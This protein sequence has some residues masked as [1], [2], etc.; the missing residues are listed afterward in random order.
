MKTKIIIF[1][2]LLTIVIMGSSSIFNFDFL[3][4][5]SM[6]VN[7]TSYDNSWKLID[8]LINRNL[9]QSAMQEVELV[10]NKAKSE[11]NVPQ[12]VKTL[13]YKAKLVDFRE[14]KSY[15]KIFAFFDDEISTARPPLKNI[16]HSVKAE[17]MWR[18]YSIN[19][20]KF[21]NRTQT[22]DFDN[23]DIETWDLKTLVDAII[24]E[25]YMAL[26]F[27]DTLKKTNLDYI[28]PILSPN[29]ADPVF[30]PTLYDFIV[31]RAITFF[32]NEEPD[33]TRPA[34]YFKI[35]DVRYFNV[36]R[37]FTNLSITNS[38]SLSLKFYALSLFQNLTAFH[39]HSDYDAALM[40]VE[41]KRL[42]FVYN[43]FEGDE[44]D[45][46]LYNA[47]L[48]LEAY[49]NGKPESAEASFEIANMDFIRG[50]KYN[51]RMG[52]E[53]KWDMK[54]AH[55]KCIEVISRYPDT[56]GAKNCLNLKERILETKIT[57]KNENFVPSNTPFLSGIEYKNI[58]KAYFRIVKSDYHTM[59][60]LLR[61]SISREALVEKFIN[62]RPVQEFS[63]DM[64][65]D[66]DYQMHSTEV[67]M[68]ELPLGYYLIIVSDNE[69]F[70]Y[71]SG[72]FAYS[73]VCI[74]DISYVSRRN[75]QG[76]YEIFVL[77]RTNG[78][79]IANAKL[80]A[81]IEDYNYRTRTYESKKWKTFTSDSEGFIKIPAERRDDY[82]SFYIEITHGDD[83][84][85]SDR[86]FYL[87][88]S[89]D[90]DVESIISTT[91]F[92]DRAIY[93]PGQTVF[94]KGIV[95]ETTGERKEIKTNYR[96]KVT[97][98]DVNSQQVGEL[99]LVSNEFGTISGSFVIP[100]G[101]MT[102]SM[103]IRSLNSAK[104]FNVEE[105]KR[106]KFEVTFEPLKGVYRLNENINAKGKAMAYA[107]NSIDGAQVQYR[108]V[109]NA[110]FPYSYY[111]WRWAFPTS[112]EVVIKVGNTTT[113]SEGL[114]EIEFNAI[115]DN[116][117]NRRFKPVF[118]Y[119]IYADVTDITGEVRSSQTTISVG[120]TALLLSAEVPERIDKNN[121]E[122]FKISTTN[123]NGEK[124]PT[125]CTVKIYRLKQ[126]AS[127]YRSRIWEAPDNNTLSESEFRRLFPKDEYKDENNVENWE[128]EE[129]VSETV[130][131]TTEI[132][133]FLPRNFERWQSGKYIME[134]SAND[135]FNQE[136]NKNYHFTLFADSDRS[137]PTN[138]ISWIKFDKTL[139]EPGE[140]VSFTL[141]TAETDVNVIYELEYGPDSIIRRW[142]NLNKE[143]KRFEIPV[144]EQDR[145]NFQVHFTFVKDNRT[146]FH[147]QAISVPHTDKVLDIQYATFRDKLQPGQNEEWRITIKDHKGDKMLAEL[148]TAMYDASLDAFV[149]NNW[150]FNILNY[151]YSS[152]YWEGATAFGTQNALVYSL[153]QKITHLPVYKIYNALNWFGFNF[154]NYGYYSYDYA[155]DSSVYLQAYAETVSTSSG[156]GS[157]R[158]SRDRAEQPPMALGGAGLMDGDKN[159]EVAEEE[160][161]LNATGIDSRNGQSG[162]NAIIGQGEGIQIRSNFNE[163]AFFFPQLKTNENGEV[164]V[165]F[166]VPESLTRWRIMNFAHTKDL[167]YVVTERELV[168]QK[169]LMITANAPRFFR[170]NDIITFTAK[171][172]NLSDRD[173]SGTAQ[174]QLFDALS[175]RPIDADLQNNNATLAFQV[176]KGQSTLLSW[177]LNIKEGTSAVT[178]RIS[179]RA[180][181]FSDGEEMAI[182]V[183]SN[184]MLVTESLPL[185]IRGRTERTFE[186][187]K[188]INS[189]SSSTLRHHK[190]TLEFTSNPAWYA[191]Q[192]LP[193]LME[194]PYECSEQIFSRYYAN[195]IATYVANSNPRIKRVFDSWRTETPEALLSN[196]EKNQELKAVLLEETPW[197]LNGRNESD[198]K[199]RIA[200]LF[201]LN[202]M[203][204]EKDRAIRQLVNNQTPNGGWPWFK[205]MPDDR[206]ITQHIVAGI[207]KLKNLNIDDWQ[208]DRRLNDA[209]VSAVRYLDNRVKEDYDLLKR[210]NEGRMH[211]DNIGQLH[212]HYLYTRSFFNNIEVDRNNKVA[213]DYYYG[214]AKQY[215]SNKSLYM[216]GMIALALHRYNET[217]EPV[218][219]VRGLKENALT[220][221][222][223]GMYWVNNRSGYYWYEAPIETQALFIEV[224]DEVTHDTTAVEEMKIWL[225]KQKQTQDWKTTKATAEAIYALILRGTDLLAS[226]ELVE[227]TMGNLV[228]DPRNLDGV[229]VEAGTGYFKTSWSG[230]EINP[231]MGR[232]KVRKPD[233]GVAW[234]ALYWQYFEQLD[235]IT[236]HETPLQLN[237]KVFV[238]EQTASGKIIRPVND[239]NTLK[240]GDK[241]IIRIELRVDRDMEYVH[242]KDMRASGFEPVNV[243]SQYKYQDG[244]G[245]YESTRDAATHF[246]FSYLRSGTYVF[247]YPMFVTHKGNFSNGI[248]TIQ[249]MYAPE[250]TSHS[251][252]IRVNVE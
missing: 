199:R 53:N 138:D 88:R 72:D 147:S 237:K 68:P 10:Y 51:P 111:G 209:V 204:H 156:R 71:L 28:K 24:K 160:I 59:Q 135:A 159:L 194:F 144:R 89:Y 145:G 133:E 166:T 79:P 131:N 211:L 173:L 155:D 69:S 179:A 123:L 195:A 125:N 92:L 217:Q 174:L 221:D 78:T 12:L 226:D 40:D 25:H 140:V 128:K 201:D 113:N 238:E 154:Y 228:V 37:D 212:I 149:R 180:D 122:N 119:T 112:R 50:L 7:P 16:L 63:K 18:Y 215:W 34:D 181:N 175:M 102:G 230:T 97:F 2:S 219:I 114:F 198:R 196:L 143:Q 47:Y 200:L 188:L 193:Y 38:D 29:E 162:E 234:G 245:Y 150:F 57:V 127:V 171:V 30:L 252:G 120:Y 13:I 101:L 17:L 248:T 107:G 77:D 136:V 65:N 90:E 6:N 94:F 35:D 60:D 117:L 224:F 124:E 192:A 178:Y 41:I 206:Y 39:I 115:P 4:I 106:P 242:M 11:N 56:Y 205:G 26:Q 250:F 216:Q 31:D 44:K 116:K 244:L 67:A 33:I 62:M 108:I 126:P 76:N 227:I 176:S 85:F 52:D 110:Y 197:L 27:Q 203:S 249:C 182:P 151:N 213:F 190:L 214:Q 42:K 19:R 81:F 229:S 247:E 137:I 132:S 84:I 139:A 218:A 184:R 5:N 223:M 3:N 232:V 91:Y 231:E 73:F 55:D 207:G 15:V 96:Q 202:K 66:N 170:E 103:S 1:F 118:N 220:S 183:L 208:T 251:E 210:Y 225:L 64:I 165:A 243:F 129:L 104:Y 187:G 74:T 20:Y 152:F 9:P 87:Y 36:L 164:V 8:S 32:S 49:F 157:A 163:T 240:V 23:K 246:F 146:Y 235:K 58:N 109:R 46:L 45:E 189:A 22:V 21:L 172:S 54:K 148:M 241:V 236:P 80:D 142:I 130:I 70:S 153:K 14:E 61:Q 75:H 83:F 82:R 233:D 43:N 185:P 169:D 141:G 99:D 168:T 222:E 186:F 134:I 177:N 95:L 121:F 161:A 105:Y 93:R 158:A 98:F 86:S 100:M 239:N 48:K 191:I 167:K